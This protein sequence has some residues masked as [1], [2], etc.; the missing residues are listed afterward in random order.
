MDLERELQ[1]KFATLVP[2]LDRKAAAA[3]RCG[4]GPIVGLRRDQS[5]QPSLG[6]SRV[7]IQAALEQL[8]RPLLHPRPRPPPRR[9]PQETPGRLVAVARS[10]GGVDRPGDP[11]RSDV[12]P[13]MG[14]QEHTPGVGGPAPARRGLIT[15]SHVAGPMLDHPGSSP[16]VTAKTLQGQQ[17]PDRNARFRYINTICGRCIA[18]DLPVISVDTEKREPIGNTPMAGG[19]GGWP[20]GVGQRPRLPRSRRRHGHPLRC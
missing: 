1:H 8:D 19:S 20:T 13:S 16:Q 11:G 3:G 18:E 5:P 6:L 15:G 10:P 7:T 17:H 4:R 9:R 2:C 14:L 12:P